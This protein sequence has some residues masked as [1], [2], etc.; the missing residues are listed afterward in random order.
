MRKPGMRLLQCGIWLG[1][2]LALLAC[3]ADPPESPLP[4][5]LQAERE[6]ALVAEILGPEGGILRVAGGPYAGTS[7]E[8]PAGAL[9]AD[10]VF[11][12]SV[13]DAVPRNLGYLAVGEMARFYSTAVQFFI[14][15]TISAPVSQETVSDGAEGHLVLLARRDDAYR[16][17]GGAVYDGQQVRALVS[18]LGDYGAAL[19]TGD[20]VLDDGTGT[21]TR[22]PF[23]PGSI[24]MEQ[25]ISNA[26]NRLSL[27]ASWFPDPKLHTVRSNTMNPCGY[28]TSWRTRWYSTGSGS[29][30]AELEYT[31]QGTSNPL[32]TDGL[33]CTFSNL[34]AMSPTTNSTGLASDFYERLVEPPNQVKLTT[35]S[36]ED[37]PKVMPQELRLEETTTGDWAIYSS[38]GVLLDASF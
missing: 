26:R 8:V 11:S 2:C 33:P 14:P 24:A 16:A 21:E 36:C 29:R 19:R 27:E 30:T 22:C 15:L 17:V 34:S 7:L 9:S 13:T 20:S 31:I 5:I 37:D 23:V 10:A 1:V 4:G 25:A 3:R 35:L 28:S 18:Q 38:A 6:T 32:Y 12:I